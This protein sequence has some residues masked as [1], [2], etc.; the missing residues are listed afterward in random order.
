[1]GGRRGS[2]HPQQLWQRGFS[3][4]LESAAQ[5][6]LWKTL[7]AGSLYVF[8]AVERHATQKGRSPVCQAGEGLPQ[9]P[10]WESQKVE[11]LRRPLVPG[12]R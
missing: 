9:L 2:I 3:F 11:N 4:C 7:K 12:E 1:M 5:T 6:T 10:V 8:D